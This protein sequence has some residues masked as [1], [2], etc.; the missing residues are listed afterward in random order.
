MGNFRRGGPFPGFP[1][2]I[3][4]NGTWNRIP[5]PKLPIWGSFQ[6]AAAHLD[7]F[8]KMAIFHVGGRF[9]TLRI[10]ISKNRPRIRIPRPKLPIWGTFYVNLAILKK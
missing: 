9:P 2:K 6:P 8:K 3:S 4:K 7:D 5:G 10:K 1:D